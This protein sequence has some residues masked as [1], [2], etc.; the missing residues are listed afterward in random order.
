MK[1]QPDHR[2]SF[3]SEEAFPA[4]IV[5][6]EQWLLTHGHHGHFKGEDGKPIYYEYYLAEGAVA[7]VVVVHGMSEFTKKYC[8]LTYYLLHQ[9]YNVFLYDQRGHGLS[10]RD[11][12]RPELIHING[13]DQLVTDLNCYIETI[14]IPASPAPLYLY[15]HSMGGAVGAMYLARYP[16]RFSRAVLTSPLFAPKMNNLP[17]WP[18]LLGVTIRKK[19]AGD[20]KKFRLS[21]EYVPG[22]PYQPASGDSPGRVQRSLWHRDHNRHYQSTPMTLGCVYHNLKLRRRILKGD[23]AGAIQTPTLMLCADQDALVKHRPQA[24]LAA[25]CP[26]I[27]REVLHGANH[28]LLTD[29]QPI[30][31]QTINRV[32]T[33]YQ[34]Q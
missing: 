21:N 2:L 27:T 7:S 33:F 18:F 25:R 22:R 3:I 30:L 14:V 23:I 31:E 24:Q 10:H 9:G 13:Y 15:A 19:F 8:E 16:K 12:D 4:A 17:A 26:A 32:L 29:A 28:A 20:L 34:A 11:T 6:L 1:V 5:E